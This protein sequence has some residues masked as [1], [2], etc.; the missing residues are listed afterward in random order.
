MKFR[1]VSLTIVLLLPAGCGESDRARQ[2][3]EVTALETPAGLGSGES[4]LAVGPDGAVVLSWL[5]PDGPGHALRFATLGEAAWSAPRTLT[6]GDDWFVNWADFP[7]VVPV[8]DTVWAAHWL[9]RQPAGGYAY[10]VVLS[11][12]TD[13]GTSWQTVGSPHAD[14]TPT[15]HGFVALFPWQAGVGVVWLDGRDTLPAGE[16]G[17]AADGYAAGGMTL[18]SALVHPDGRRSHELLIDDLTCDC[19]QTDVVVSRDGP[20]VAYRDRTV[21]EK[22]DVLVARFAAGHWQQPVAVGDDD[23]R[24]DGCP[25]NG[26][27]L[28]VQG[29]SVVVAWFTAADDRPRVRLARSTDGGRS[30]A[31][32]LDADDTAPL[33]RVDVVLMPGGD[34]LV[35]WLRPEKDDAVIAL[36]RVGRDGDLG[37]IR[38]VARTA[39]GR[40]SGFPQ[41]VR[42]G[43]D[44]IVSWTEAGEGA[45]RVR[46]ARI[47]ADGV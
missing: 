47:A 13:G 41:L 8:S 9:A 4:H 25:V 33:G 28:D 3:F 38:V 18:R 20:L 5:E 22:R 1:L 11:L 17:G 15:E 34:A 45:S 30:F 43:T 44:L 19:C 40:L 37:P 26:P 46:S 2:A 27:A 10:D 32:T 23:W 31:T 21:D 24:I 6:R 42:S 29:E 16:Q 7:S 35:S 14:R 39:A 12:S 36:R